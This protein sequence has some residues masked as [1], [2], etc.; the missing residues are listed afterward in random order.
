MVGQDGYQFQTGRKRPPAAGAEID[1]ALFRLELESVL[2]GL[3]V[4]KP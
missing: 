2:D 3:H 1:E 4:G